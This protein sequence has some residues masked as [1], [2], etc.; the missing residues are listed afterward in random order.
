MQK[1]DYKQ[2]S[3][4]L[5]TVDSIILQHYLKEISNKNYILFIL[6][7]KFNELSSNTKGQYFNIY[8]LKI[9]SEYGLSY[10]LNCGEIRHKETN[11]PQTIDW[12]LIDDEYITQ[13]NHDILP[14][15]IKEIDEFIEREK[16]KFIN[17][18]HADNRGTPK[19]AIIFEQECKH[20]YQNLI[21]IQQQIQEIQEIQEVQEK[22]KVSQSNNLDDCLIWEE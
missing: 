5:T 14:K 16:D 6:N 2:N 11:K 4:P 19:R 3:L 9:D 22:N 1:L 13:L 21:N 7:Y 12:V 20:K 15:I 17:S 18:L 8:H 10:P